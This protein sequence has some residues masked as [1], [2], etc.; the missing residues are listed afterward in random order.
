MPVFDFDFARSCTNLDMSAARSGIFTPNLTSLELH[1]QELHRFNDLARQLAPGQ[2]SFTL[3]QIAGA[4]RRVLRAPANGQDSTFIKV[5][6][7]RAGEMRAAYRDIKWSMAPALKADLS[8][9]LDYLDSGTGLIP[10]HIPTVG[11]LDDSILVDVAMVKFRTELD[12]YAD[13]CRFRV[14]EAAQQ[15]IAVDAVDIDRNRWFVERQQEQRLEQQLRR[16]R[17]SSYAKN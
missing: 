11:L 12:E 7:R 13:F 17:S 1:D 3:D 9:L 2:P 16:V 4:A 8:G 5:R 10:N 14:A 15:D 6:M